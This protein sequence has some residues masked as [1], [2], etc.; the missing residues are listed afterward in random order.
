MNPIHVKEIVS[1]QLRRTESHRPPIVQVPTK[2]ESEKTLDDDLEQFSL[3]DKLSDAHK[4]AILFIVA[5]QGFLGPLTSSIYVPAIHEVRT[6]L[7]TSATVINITISL[8]ILILGV[9]PLGWASL[10]ERYGRRMVYILAT[11]VYIIS[12]IG[13]ALSNSVILFSFMRALQ[14]VGAGAAQAVGAGTITDLFVI[15]DRGAAM[16]L[17]FMGPLIGPVLGPIAGGFINELLNWRFIFWFLVILGGIVLFLVVFFL[18]ETSALILK[19]KHCKKMDIPYEIAAEPVS[20]TM[21]RPFKFM[22]KPEVLLATTPYSIAFG[23]MY[24]VIASLPHQLTDQYAYSSSQIGLAYLANGIGNALGAL[25]SGK[26]SDI[27][28]TNRRG[29]ITLENRL[30]PM[31]LGICILPVGQVVYG[32]STESG[33]NV[34]SCLTGLFFLGFGVGLVQTPSNTYIVDAY[35]DRS[36][37]VMS[38]ANLL[39]CISAAANPLVAPSLIQS[40][41]NGWSMSILSLLSLLSGLCIFVT[42]R[43]GA[44]WR[45]NMVD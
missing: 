27:F 15:Q 14:A 4:W 41:G 3:I 26:L 20:T 21:I 33:L 43:Y 1:N 7:N 35:S 23:S 37:V 44:K 34:S 39:R 8:Y 30:N 31:W 32:W 25:L 24:F 6:A 42:Q 12:T 17:F 29:V 36:A 40:I 2:N 18:P 13:C 38:T 5:L 28:L 10:S 22:I 9:A 19:K 16:G 45:E 11:L